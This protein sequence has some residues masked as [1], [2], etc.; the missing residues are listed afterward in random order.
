MPRFSPASIR[1]V[2]LLGPSTAGK[3][4]L[5][6]ALLREA[7]VINS[8]GSVE[9]GTTQSDFDAQE[10]ER[11]HS[12]N[13][14]IFSFDFQDCHINL[15]DAPGLSDFRGAAFSAM[16]AVETV[17]LVIN[18]QTGPDASAIKIWQRA[19]TRG[20]ECVIVI[21]RIDAPS[22]KPELV[23]QQLRERLGSEVLPINLPNK[24]RSAVVDCFFHQNG[25][26]EFSSPAIAHQQ[27]IDQIVEVNPA[28]MERYLDQGEAKISAQELHDC[29][30][31]CLR[32]GHLIP[33]CFTSAKSGAGVKELLEI[34]VRLFPN[35]AEGNPPAFE[36][37]NGT[38][39]APVNAQVNAELHVI[40]HTFKIINDPFMGKLS[41]FRMH[42][43]TIKKESQ[44]YVG[45][46]KKPFRVAHLYKLMGKTPVEIDAA[47]A[48]DICAVAKVED[49]HFD[50]VVHDHPDEADWHLQ[51]LDF[52]KSMFGLSIQPATRGQEQKL[53]G[54]LQKLAEEDPTFV[55]EHHVDLNETVILGLGD[56][57]LKV[58]LARLKERF[59]LDVQTAPP[60][61][62]YKE[63]I[64]LE[65]EGHHRHK[66]QTGGAGQFGEVFLRIKPLARGAGFQ[67]SDDTKGGSIPHNFIPAVEKGVRL[68]LQSG[69][70][71]GYGLQDLLV[72]AYDGKHHPVDSK[73]VAFVSAGKHALLD[74][75]SKAR[76][77]ILE[78]IVDLYVTIPEPA[79]GGVTALLSGKRAKIMGTDSAGANEL[80]LHA[81]VPMAELSDFQSELTAQTAGQGNFT[82]DYSHDELVP[83]SVQKRLVD[84]YKP[85]FEED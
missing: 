82:M 58:M 4:T 18:A 52:P 38:Q 23:L 26:T 29:F 48:G 79:M 80:S 19:K 70:I 57:H 5:T 42:Q 55:V 81:Q 14:S 75:I 3:T 7:G 32:E 11:L 74:A 47:I 31:Q 40:A 59:Q 12:L 20:H 50:A 73:E 63:T 69:A 6:E 53:S 85:K 15:I 8:I 25:E 65:S 33:V 76:P 67:F 37:G 16:A 49:L 51:A 83:A 71:A 2:C 84:A 54:A 24:N 9:R 10:K 22:A 43:G 28:V 21:N 66:K 44:L 13:A 61:I 45:L 46:G 41:I 36:R 60:R 68:V 35:P 34:M 78:P 62:A 72:S 17:V 27:I 30:E 64:T 1:N 77:C 39:T 56:L